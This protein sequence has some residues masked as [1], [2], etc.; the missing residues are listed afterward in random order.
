MRIHPSDLL[1]GFHYTFF[2]FTLEG[3]LLEW[4]WTKPEIERL[5]NFLFET[6]INNPLNYELFASISAIL[7]KIGRFDPNS[8]RANPALQG[9]DSGNSLV[10]N[11]PGMGQKENNNTVAVNADLRAGILQRSLPVEQ[12]EDFRGWPVDRTSLRVGSRNA[13]LKS[14][15]ARPFWAESSHHQGR[16]STLLPQR[17][18]DPSAGC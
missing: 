11:L 16:Q 14:T 18:H 15:E 2:C 1:V 17:G 7:T 12:P 10:A 9:R 5:I 8:R 6:H 4:F 3:K 13:V